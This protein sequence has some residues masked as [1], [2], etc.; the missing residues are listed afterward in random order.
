MFDDPKF[1]TMDD[2]MLFFRP[3]Y[4]APAACGPAAAAGRAGTRKEGVG[5]KRRLP[6]QEKGEEEVEEVLH[7]DVALRRK[8][9]QTTTWDSG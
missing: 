2:K 9:D 3:S 7:V 4:L 6:K 8:R 5:T 1:G